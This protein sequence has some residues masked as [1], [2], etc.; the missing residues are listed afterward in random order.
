[1]N[2]QTEAKALAKM[3]WAGY[4]LELFIEKA[5]S[6]DRFYAG[7][8]LCGMDKIAW[9]P[10]RSPSTEDL[11]VAVIEAWEMGYADGKGDWE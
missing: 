5:N 11:S 6:V 8:Y 10:R 1:M 2:N 4:R 9:H 3:Y 7:G